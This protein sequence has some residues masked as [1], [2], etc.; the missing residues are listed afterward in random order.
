MKKIAGLFLLILSASFPPAFT[1]SMVNNGSDIYVSPQSSITIV[2]NFINLSD[3]NLDNSGRIIL[4]GNWTNNAESGNLLQGSTG[5]LIFNGANPQII[6]GTTSTWF[7]NLQ[8]EQEAILEADIS[9]SNLLELLNAHVNLNMN[10]L[11]IEEGAEITGVGQQSYIVAD[12]NGQLKRVVGSNDVFFPVGTNIS[13]TPV[14]LS[15]LGAEDQ[16]GVG[17][18]GDV[19]DGGLSGSTIS[20]IN[21]CVNLTWNI[22]EMSAGESDLMVE[23]FWNGLDEGPDFDR[24]HSSL[25]YFSNGNWVPRDEGEAA[26]S[27]PFSISRSGITTPG[28]FA[29]GDLESPMAVTIGLIDQQIVIT[30]GWSGISTYIDPANANVDAMYQPIVN[31]LI[32]LQSETG[33]YWPGENLNTIGAWDAHSGFKIK[34]TNEVELTIS[35]SMV[36]NASVDIFEGW[37]LIPVLSPDN[38]DV[39][40]IFSMIDLALA[41]DVAGNGVYWPEYN[42]NTLQNLLPGKSYFVLANAIGSISYSP[43]TKSSSTNISP[44]SGINSPWNPINHGP[45]SHVIA[46][47]QGS[48]VNFNQGDIIAT[49]NEN[50]LCTG[51]TEFIDGEIVLVSYGDDAI[52][53]EV[54]GMLPNEIFS[55]QLFRPA[56]NMTYELEIGYEKEF[57]DEGVFVVNGLSIVSDLKLSLLNT[58]ENDLAAINLYPNPTT[59]IIN[60]DGINLESEIVIYNVVGKIFYSNR[61]TGKQSIDMTGQPKGLYVVKISNSDGIIYKK[62][63]LD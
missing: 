47:T 36:E 62:F 6:G 19:L 46:F 45:S 25:G 5:K 29:V 33:I 18:F 16:F 9:V 63:I 17:V 43:A 4:T 11:I 50:G 60:I 34:V 28:A 30:E 2:G 39:V 1:Q 27:D 49:F 35:G 41:K 26:G 21:D 53:G 14:T 42:I 48:L 59:A 55:W 13:Y 8:L 20:E 40:E 24:M 37:N 57:D 32:I 31:E 44:A 54:D 3:G 38:T 61:L 15:N 10:H 58:T 56:T 52:T 23:T 22:Q 7:S 51:I 12:A